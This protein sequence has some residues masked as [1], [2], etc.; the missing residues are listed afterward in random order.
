MKAHFIP[1]L[2]EQPAPLPLER[3]GG[4]L[5]ESQLRVVWIQALDQAGFRPQT[6]ALLFGSIIICVNKGR[7][8]W[9][10][11]TVIM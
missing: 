1:G 11:K 10:M 3:A 9:I 6:V 4:F 7:F 8:V 5:F 2:V